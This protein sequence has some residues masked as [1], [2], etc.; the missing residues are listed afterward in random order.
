[1]VVAGVVAG[2]PFGPLGV[3]IG[4]S[5]VSL[6]GAM[7]YI[8]YKAGRQ[9]SVR[10]SDLWFG[11]IKHLP[12]WTAVFGSATVVRFLT[13]NYSSVFQ[14]LIAVPAG[15]SAGA[16]TIFLWKDSRETAAHIVKTISE[17]LQHRKGKT[18]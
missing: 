12:V 14:L 3:A 1:M 8:Y 16:V 5:F 9:G 10:T 2:L 6:L 4:L 11:F 17:S 7:P 15:L 18:A 13:S